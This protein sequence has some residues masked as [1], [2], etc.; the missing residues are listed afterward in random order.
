MSSDKGDFNDSTSPN[1]PRFAIDPLTRND[2]GLGAD[3]FSDS[4][5]HYAQGR[6][7]K[8]PI[9]LPPTSAPMQVTPSSTLSMDPL[10]VLDDRKG[11]SYSKDSEV[12]LQFDRETTSHSLPTSLHLPHY[13]GSKPPTLPIK[14]IDMTNTPFSSPNVANEGFASDSSSNRFVHLHDAGYSPDH[15]KVESAS[16]KSREEGKRELEETL[17]ADHPYH[18]NKYLS[19]RPDGALSFGE[20]TA[21][22]DEGLATRPLLGNRRYTAADIY[23][24]SDA[25][26]GFNPYED[27][28]EGGSHAYD[29]YNSDFINHKRHA[30]LTLFTCGLWAPVWICACA[31]ICCMRPCSN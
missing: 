1:A 5:D 27:A 31:K 18:Q 23:G 9:I 13:A 21:S 12:R 17:P 7:I 3:S 4:P 28:F 16:L 8:V 29:G 10:G 14:A 11:S 22:D 25:E 30:L 6:Q 15:V 19:T 26:A 20:S 24:T 2:Y